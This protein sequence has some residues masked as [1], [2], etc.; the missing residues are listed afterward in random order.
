MAHFCCY[1]DSEMGWMES[2]LNPI[3]F[4]YSVQDPIRDVGQKLPCCKQSLTREWFFQ[5]FRSTRS[6][7]ALNLQGPLKL[8]VTTWLI[9]SMIIHSWMKMGQ[10]AHWKPQTPKS[11]RVA[12]YVE[13][14]LVSPEG[15]LKW[16]KATRA[17]A[18]PSS[19][20]KR[21]KRDPSLQ[22]RNHLQ[23]CVVDSRR[24]LHFDLI[25]LCGQQ[26]MPFVFR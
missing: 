16:F 3:I 5:Y 24:Q 13:M 18:L 20:E 2:E 15:S 6:P 21:A 26:R 11:L 9:Q 19:V 4:P 25:R 12:G 7:E 8:R 14:P 17:G 23:C 22:T 1:Y 10:I